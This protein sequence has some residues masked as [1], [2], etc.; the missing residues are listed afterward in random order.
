MCRHGKQL[1]LEFENAKWP[2][3]KSTPTMFHC[4]LAM[5]LGMTGFMAVRGEPRVAY[6]NTDTGDVDTWPPRFT[7]LELDLV[8]DAKDKSE[9]T[10]VAFADA[11]R[12]GSVKLLR[13]RK[14]D[15][16]LLAGLGPDGLDLPDSFPTTLV[17]RG[18]RRPIKSALLDQALLAGVGNWVADEV[19]LTARV[20]PE[21]R[22]C[23][24]S[25]A[26]AAAV[27]AAVKSVCETAI[28]VDADAERYPPDWLF[29]VR[30]DQKPGTK[31]A[32][33]PVAWTTIG[34]RTTAYVPALQK[35]TDIKTEVKPEGGV[36]PPPPPP[37]P[38]RGKRRA[39]APPPARARPT[40]GVGIKK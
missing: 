24:L 23:D 40:R 10:A 8:P 35:K 11:R 37:P 34:G 39:A 1:W 13:G 28:A 6:V 16:A 31:I 29:H 7:K 38:P 26:Q 3:R 12:F 20:H 18:G 15:D 32:G 17:T 36:A 9:V 33:H 14:G 2:P 25:P 4:S 27:T 19:L 5:H 22:A 21:A 30:W